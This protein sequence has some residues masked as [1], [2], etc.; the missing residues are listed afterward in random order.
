M[1]TTSSTSS[2]TATALTPAKRDSVLNDLVDAIINKTEVTTAQIAKKRRLTPGTVA[3]V[4]ANF[5]RGA[6]GTTR[7][8][9]SRRRKALQSS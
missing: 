4:R 9:V 3:A 5:T 7:T 6:Y 8:L 2:S 1:A